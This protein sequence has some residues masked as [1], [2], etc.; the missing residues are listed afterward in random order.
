MSTTANLEGKTALLTL[1]E[2]LDYSC[3]STPADQGAYERNPLG[4]DGAWLHVID[5]H[6]VRFT[7]TATYTGT[8]GN[9]SYI[10][11]DY[12]TEAI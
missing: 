6:C 5:L 8:P 1:D 10:I 4:Y 2:L 11:H 9:P 3:G 12:T 7:V